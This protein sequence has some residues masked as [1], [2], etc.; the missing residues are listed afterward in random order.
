M[1]DNIEKFISKNR[2]QFD[3]EEPSPDLWKSVEEKL[4]A[5]PKRIRMHPLLYAASLAG[6][7]IAAWLL[8]I[9][10]TQVGTRVQNNT[11]SVNQ[12]Q[13]AA[14]QILVHDT[15]LL[16]DQSENQIKPSQS[17]AP[18]NPKTDAFSEITEYYSAEIEKRRDKLY[19]ISSGNPEI[20]DQVEEELAMVDTLNA[21]AYRDLNRNMHAGMVM[22][23]RVENYKL[24]IDI[25]DMMLEQVNEE[26]ANI[27]Q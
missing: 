4:P 22:E 25:L 11:I 3:N 12:E 6:V 26:Y 9:T 1:E 5:Q 18:E 21:Q 23:Q 20:I 14:Q 16:S 27:N 10:T 13:P 8:V 7:A 24:C 2:A 15:I 17:V 19:T